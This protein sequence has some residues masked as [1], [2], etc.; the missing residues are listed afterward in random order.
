MLEK[1]VLNQIDN[2]SVGLT[3]HSGYIDGKYYKM[4]EEANGYL[5]DGTEKYYF[6]NGQ[7]QSGLKKVGS[8]TYY[9]DSATKLAVKNQLK[10]VGQKTYY[11]SHDGSVQ[12][13]VD[14]KFQTKLIAHRGA[15]NL[16]PENSLPAFQLAKGSYGAETDIW[17]TKDKQWV[18]SHDGTIDRMTNGQGAIK[19]LTLAQI[20]QYHID[21]GVNVEK[22]KL[23]TLPTLKEYL[24]EMS[25][26]QLRPIIEI[27]QPADQMS[28]SDVQS[29]MTTIKSQHLY[30]QSTIISL[31]ADVLKHIYAL[32]KNISLELLWDSSS[33]AT[34]LVKTLNELGPKAGL[35]INGK[36]LTLQTIQTLKQQKRRLNVWTISPNEFPYYIGLG[37]D[38]I[39]TDANSFSLN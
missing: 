19:D 9:F 23:L 10:T 28:D 17:L 2:D 30:K 33:E 22:Y 38:E 25:Y 11:F 15:S 5:S 39:T 16:A 13:L 6:K 34:D 14:G 12:Y 1:V 26:N 7:R 32:D 20:K 27:K 36:K 8:K 29:L 31:Q 3:P 37:V 18:V 24:A 4:A 35:D 21:S